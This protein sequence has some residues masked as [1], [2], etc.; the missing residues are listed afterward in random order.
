MKSAPLNHP[1]KETH[2]KVVNN[3]LGKKANVES[4]TNRIYIN[5]LMPSFTYTNHKGELTSGKCASL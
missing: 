5:T 4:S 3:T 2:M 1:Q